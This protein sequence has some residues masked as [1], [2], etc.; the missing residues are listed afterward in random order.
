MRSNYKKIV[1]YTIS[2]F[3]IFIFLS[4]Y[5]Y[6][7][8]ASNWRTGVPKQL[9]N[10]SYWSMRG[11]TKNK[12]TN[13]LNHP[14]KLGNRLLI[15]LKFDKQNISYGFPQAGDTGERVIANKKVDGG[16]ILKCKGYS[17]GTNHQLYEIMKIKI[18]KGNIV[19]FTQFYKKGVLCNY[20]KGTIKHL[21]STLYKNF[22]PGPN[23]Y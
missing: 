6:N 3:S 14:K 22:Y 11:L 23:R 7:V 2:M 19:R 1:F 20:S 13:F 16:F 12:I 4:N 21:N 9:E 17:M 15:F 8:H 10:K 5:S 18:K